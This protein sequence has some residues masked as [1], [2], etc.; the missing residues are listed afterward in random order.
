MSL[1]VV[2]PLPQLATGYVMRRMKINAILS[3][4]KR[5]KGPSLGHGPMGWTCPRVGSIQSWP[6]EERIYLLLSVIERGT[7]HATP[8]AFE[9][10]QMLGTI[11]SLDNHSQWQQR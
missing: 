5:Q 4:R 8:C 10:F 2:F 11:D 9:I 7:S 1:C 6:F 3:E